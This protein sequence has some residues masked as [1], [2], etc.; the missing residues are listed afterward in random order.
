MR[1]DGKN[2]FGAGKRAQSATLASLRIDDDFCHNK[3]LFNIQT[4]DNRRR[5]FSFLLVK[6]PPFY[7]AF[8][9]LPYV[10]ISHR[11]AL[12]VLR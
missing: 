12:R 1:R 7:K 11:E 8:S 5:C 4:A 3:P 6:E 10:V 2:F 9:L